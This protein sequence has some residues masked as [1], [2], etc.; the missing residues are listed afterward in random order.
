MTLNKIKCIA[1]IIAVAG[2]LPNVVTASTSTGTCPYPFH[3]YYQ[4][5]A[6]HQKTEKH[7]Q[8]EKRHG[9]FHP[10]TQTCSR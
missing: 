10:L 1:T 4:N 6:C 2:I 5:G 7:L 3:E 8:C 9:T